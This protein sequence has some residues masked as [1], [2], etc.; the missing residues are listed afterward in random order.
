[1][2]YPGQTETVLQGRQLVLHCLEDEKE[3]TRLGCSSPGRTPSHLT[4]RARQVLQATSIFIRFDRGSGAAGRGS[5]EDIVR[6][7]CRGREVTVSAQKPSGRGWSDGGCRFSRDCTASRNH[8]MLHR[9]NKGHLGGITGTHSALVIQAEVPE[10]GG[11]LM[12]NHRDMFVS[13]HCRR[14]TKATN[15]SW[16]DVYRWP[17]GERRHHSPCQDFLAPVQMVMCVH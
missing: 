9:A 13:E 16:A 4:F 8:L 5:R 14:A 7:G 17:L 1:M 2:C 11:T 10:P 6:L 12:S 3:G 15:D